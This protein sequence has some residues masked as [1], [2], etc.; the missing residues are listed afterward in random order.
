MY[1]K[2]EYEEVLETLDKLIQRG[3]ERLKSAEQ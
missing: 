2:L 3:E 1:E